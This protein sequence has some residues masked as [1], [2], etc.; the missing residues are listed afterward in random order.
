MIHHYHFHNSFCVW[1][2]HV[3]N[4][5]K[6]GLQSMWNAIIFNRLLQRGYG[7]VASDPEFSSSS[8]AATAMYYKH[9]LGWR[10]AA[11]CLRTVKLLELTLIII[12]KMN[13]FGSSKNGFRECILDFHFFSTK[14]TLIKP[15]D[16][17]QSPLSFRWLLL[18]KNSLNPNLGV[19][20]IVVF[21]N[22]SLV[23]KS[24][25]DETLSLTL[26]NLFILYSFFY[27]KKSVK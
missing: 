21:I 10:I 17:C 15:R 20:I 18:G 24:S 19:T 6:I 14:K 16:V 5:I 26:C 12:Y 4:C 1:R 3:M 7:I 13:V 8:I 27:V 2:K 22:L 11:P 9:I 25:S 23:V